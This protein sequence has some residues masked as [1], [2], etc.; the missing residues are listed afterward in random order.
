[1]ALAKQHKEMRT[2][3]ACSMPGLKRNFLLSRAPYKCPVIHSLAGIREKLSQ[4]LA[5]CQP[6]KRIHIPY[7]AVLRFVYS[8]HIPDALAGATSASLPTA[9][10]KVKR[11]IL[12][13]RLPRG[14][15]SQRKAVGQCFQWGKK[16]GKA[17]PGWQ[18][19]GPAGCSVSQRRSSA[20]L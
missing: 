18:S 4:H 6:T 16:P 7:A 15:P 5:R 12:A 1:M 8:D 10:A 3:D 19:A 9:L 14:H 13:C 17:K 11:E 2:A 20:S